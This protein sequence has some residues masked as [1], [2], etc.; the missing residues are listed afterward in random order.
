MSE[1]QFHS[2]F[3]LATV[4]IAHMDLDGCYKCVNQKLSEILG[5]RSEELIGR[6]FHDFTHPEDLNAGLDQLQLLLA[7]TIP[8]F[9]L[10]KRYYR[11]SGSVIWALLTVSLVRDKAEKPLFIISVI[12]EIT[13]HK[14]EEAR[15]KLA[16][17]VLELLTPHDLQ[18]SKLRDTLHLIHAYSGIEAVGLRL[19]EGEDYPYYETAGFSKQFVIAENVLCAEQN[20]EPLLDT[21]GNPVL[22]CMCGNVICAR[23]DPAQPFFTEGGSFWT[24][25]TTDLLASTSECDLQSITRNRCNAENYESVALIPLRSEKK[26]FGLLQLNDSRRDMFTPETIRFYEQLAASV[27]TVLAHQATKKELARHRDHLAEL[28]KE[29]TAELENTN[30]FL[31]EEAVKRLQTEE[32]LLQSKETKSALLNATEDRVLLLKSDASIIDVNRA[33]ADGLGETPEALLGRNAYDFLPAEII[34]YRS[35]QFAEV[36][37]TGQPVRFQDQRAGVWLDNTLFPIFDHQKRVDRIAIFSRDITEQVLTEEALRESEERFRAIADYTCDWESWF[38][39]DGKLLWLNPSVERLTGYSVQDCLA[40]PDY[41]HSMIH[42]DD[43]ERFQQLFS[44]AIKTRTSANDITLRVL[45]KDGSLL[46]LALCWQPIFNTK[47]EYL[48]IRSSG[49]DINQRK[50]AEE[51]LLDYQQKLRSLSSKLALTEEQERR[52]IASDLHDNLGQTL[53]LAKLKLGTLL[54]LLSSKQAET[55]AKEISAMLTESIAYTRSLTFE[56]SPPI[57]YALDFTE[58]VEWLAEQLLLKNGIQ[59]RVVYD[60]KPT[61]MSE[62]SRVL[63]FKTVRELLMN[64]V[65]HAQATRVNICLQRQGN[66]LGIEIIDDGK[67]FDVEREESRNTTQVSYGLFSVRERMAYLGGTIEFLCPPGLGTQIS[68][69]APLQETT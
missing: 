24:N 26:I 32:A 51:Q 37:S 28:V 8:T 61:P 39:P 6:T 30:R 16:A 38:A 20:G 62:D 34:P 60:A 41:P 18:P 13:K 29:Q 23:T 50:Q 33:M 19:Q 47:M 49:R 14:H 69:M 52:R 53:A 12:Q 67:G 54:E 22:V 40:M 25:S 65:K 55:L 48:G 2:S 21:D 68:I 27:G 56:V 66:H 4:G 63:L 43:R 35:T 1:H 9:A 57:L 31:L 7:G 5:Y 36:I 17:Q 64:I 11:K 46:W 10:E 42:L 44:P 58:T 59:V 45:R 15:Q 3:E